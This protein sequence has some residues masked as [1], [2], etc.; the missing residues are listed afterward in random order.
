[1]PSIVYTPAEQ[2]QLD[3]V[4]K[5]VIDA[6]NTLQGY[7]NAVTSAYNS[8]ATEFSNVSGSCYKSKPSSL[9]GQLSYGSMNVG[10]CCNHTTHTNATVNACKNGVGN[11]NYYWNA[12]KSAQANVVSA[13]NAL[14]VALATQKSVTDSVN[15]N[16]DV[17]SQAATNLASTVAEGQA[18]NT[19]KLFFG[20]ITVIIVLVA[21][22]VGF[23]ILGGKA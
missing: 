22:Y 20:I 5:A 16:A 8:M 15:S 11:F 4:N 10:S 13:Q 2:A 9:E 21:V 1:M 6:Q 14:N 7:K 17:T 23:K 3:A 19:Q 18:K 12:W